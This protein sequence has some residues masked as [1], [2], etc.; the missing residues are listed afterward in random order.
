MAFKQLVLLKSK[1][2]LLEPKSCEILKFSENCPVV[3]P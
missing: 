1:I 2:V 3:V